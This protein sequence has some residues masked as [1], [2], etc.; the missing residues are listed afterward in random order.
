MSRYKAA[1][2]DDEDQFGRTLVE[3]LRHID[4]HVRDYRDPDTLICETFDAALPIVEHPDLVIVDLKQSLNYAQKMKL[5]S[6]LTD[7]D[8]VSE[9]LV[10]SQDLS[11]DLESVTKMGA[12]AVSR[13]FR[14]CFDLM[15]K[16]KRLAEIGKRRRLYR[17][18]GGHAH[19][20]DSSRLHRP[21]FLSFSHHDLSLATGFRRNLETLGVPVWYSTIDPGD[22]WRDRVKDGIDQASVFVALITDSYLDSPYCVGEFMRFHARLDSGEDPALLLLPL[23]VRNLGASVSDEGK[24]LS[25][26]I[27]DRYQYVDMTTRFIDRLTAV[28]WQIQSAVGE[29]E[30]E[31]PKR[32]G[33]QQNKTAAPRLEGLVQHNYPKRPPKAAERQRNQSPRSGVR[34]AVN[35]HLQR[36]AKKRPSHTDGLQKP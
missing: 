18:P 21:V 25:A 16:L 3:T 14:D 24:A 22:H 17:S 11:I 9:I 36:S 10:F 1:V 7:R 15:R 5:V 31:G 29:D 12:G 35:G 8:V 2:L 4:F 26:S 28:L 27:S 6:T 30:V 19:G 34:R 23:R 32:G 13:S 33:T 20:I